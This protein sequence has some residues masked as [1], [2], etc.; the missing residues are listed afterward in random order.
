ML[1]IGFDQSLN[2]LATLTASRTATLRP[3][4]QKGS[5]QPV[6]RFRPSVGLP[7]DVIRARPDV[8]IAERRLAAAT[9]RVGVAEAA[10]WPSVSLTGNI[11]PTSVRGGANPT[12]WAIGPQINL[13]IFTGGANKA[14]LNAAESRAVQAEIGWRSAVLTAIEEVENGLSAYNRG[15]KNVAAQRNLVATVGETVTLARESWQGGQTDFLTVLDAERS[16]LT[17]RSALAMAIRDHSAGYLAIS[18]AA[19]APMQ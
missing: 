4:L 6:A 16:L 7:A 15:A 12:T 9:A 8:Q 10:F 19:A 18:I 13:P 5:A 1:E 2:R 11:T 17:A 3:E 14:N